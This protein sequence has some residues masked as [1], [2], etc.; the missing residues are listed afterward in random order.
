MTDMYNTKTNISLRSWLFS[1]IG[2]LFLS[3][4]AKSQVQTM[5]WIGGAGDWNDLTHWSFQSG[6]QGATQPSSVPTSETHVIF[7]SNSGLNS[8]GTTSA[9]I[10]ARTVTL[11]A[12]VVIKSLTFDASLA[13]YSPIIKNDFHIRVSENVVWQPNVTMTNSSYA[14]SM[15]PLINTTSTLTLNGGNIPYVNKSG[16][17]N[18]DII[19]EITAGRYYFTS[20]TT[21]YNAVT[22][23]FAGNNS[24]SFQV[25]NNAILNMPY[26]TKLETNVGV[27]LNGTAQFNAPLL[28]EWTGINNAFSA[29]TV[30]STVHLNLPSLQIWNLASSAAG[31]AN[32]TITIP[33]NTKITTTGG[34]LFIG[35]FNAGTSEFYIG[36]DLTTKAN[37]LLNKVH[38]TNAATPVIRGNPVINELY[39]TANGRFSSTVTI[40]KLYLSESKNYIVDNNVTI[41]ITDNIIDNTPD[42]KPFYSIVA[43]NSIS[44]GNI[45]NA[46]G[47]PINLKNA[48]ISGIK[49]TSGVINVEGIDAD[50][51]STVGTTLFFTEPAAKTIYWVGSGLDDEWN[52]QVNWSATSGGT[53]G[54]CLPTMY[55]NVIFDN[56][57]IIVGNTLKI[58]NNAANVHDL[59][60]Q[61]NFSKSTLIIGNSTININCYGS[62]YMK[63]GVSVNSP[64]LFDAKELN[65]KITSNGSTFN[66]VVTFRNIGGWVLQDDFKTGSNTNYHINFVGGTL[67]TNNKKVFIGG[68]FAGSAA[69]YPTVASGGYKNLILGSS[70]ISL[71]N[72][73]SYNLIGSNLNAGTSHII[74]R[75]GTTF[76]ALNGHTYFNVTSYPLTV[77]TSNTLTISGNNV[78]Y[79][80][81]YIYNAGVIINATN[82]NF[83]ELRIMPVQLRANV[84]ISQNITANTLELQSNAIFR[85]DNAKIITVNQDFITHTNDCMGLMEM[86]VNGKTAGQKFTLKALNN[87]F[88]PNVW[89]TGV[90][91]DTSTG[92]TYSAT[93][94]EE[95]DVLGWN[96]LVPSPKELY[97]IGT[98]DNN[99]N[100]GLNW[101][102]NSNGI[103]SAGG[104]VPTK[105]DNV[106]FNSYSTANLPIHILDQ[107]AYFNNLIAH[108]DA[109]SGIIITYPSSANMEAYAYGNLIQMGENMIFNRLYLLGGHS[110]G[111]LINKG[112]SSFGNLTVNH[113]TANW[114]FINNMKHTSTY[115]QTGATV[116]VNAQDWNGRDFAIN[117]LALNL[118]LNYLT[119]TGTF[120]L[121]KGD[122]K[123]SN[124]IM[125]VN[126]F[127]SSG[128]SPITNVRSIDIRNSKVVTKND[129]FYYNLP[130]ATLQAD[131]SHITFNRNFYGIAGHIYDVIETDAATTNVGSAYYL[132]GNI[133]ANK[134]IVNKS[135]RILDNNTF[136]TLFLKPRG[137]TLWVNNTQ[138][139]TQHLY[140]SGTP[141]FTNVLRA[142]TEIGLTQANATASINLSNSTPTIS[143][144]EN[145]FDYVRIGGINATNSKMFLQVNATSIGL[146]TNV[147]SIPGTP[148]LIGLGPDVNCQLIDPSAPST[149]LISAEKFYAGP[150]ATFTWF[151]KVNGIYQNLNLPDTTREIDVRSFGY[152]GEYKVELLYD[153]LNTDASKRCPQTDEILVSYTPPNVTFNAGENIHRFCDSINGM[154]INDF[155]VSNATN[156][157]MIDRNAT[158][159]WFSTATGGTALNATDLVVEGSYYAEL[160]SPLG[161]V[162]LQ[163]SLVTVIIDELVVANAGPD[164]VKIGNYPLTYTMAANQTTVGS[165]KWTVLSGDVSISNTLA[166]DTTVLL[167]SGDTAVLQWEI[168]NESCTTNS[169]VTLT[170][171]SVNP[172]VNPNLRVRVSN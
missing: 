118:N 126:N 39:F 128:N 144:A 73:W 149:Y 61:D 64:V 8:V 51:N 16:E 164:Q 55:D 59:T 75:N 108:N 52:N 97:W 110:D 109:P 42:C 69:V 92:A 3:L 79:N 103:P 100:N 65:E 38:L 13:Q 84:N 98:A 26:V 121:T 87:T 161:C 156:N 78:N 12:E 148:G 165:G 71:Y 155:N 5:Y 157:D 49:V 76:Q 137:L 146:N 82:S 74:F 113:P 112:T 62:W 132:G 101:T 77:T 37:T 117:G 32:A 99:W 19:G 44:I 171:S 150:E 46:S 104:C 83:Q 153:P 166:Y 35:N 106:H 70:E 43:Q 27:T 124:L 23:K 120:T 31:N 158:I 11:K 14:I 141:C 63:S 94:L 33:D 29:L 119:A 130:S 172:K 129:W 53:G 85:V 56:N 107:P 167:N 28:N 95:T 17:G 131:G 116:T 111:Q 34:W 169:S 145:T 91:A 72:S 66:Q 20:G 15:E 25:T 36:G 152:D 163:R 68:N 50:R 9:L 21:N 93:G 90:H 4:S 41:T 30:N 1:L 96:F 135:K 10:N 127:V 138:T 125:E 143:N 67:N 170:K 58:T 86:Y 139:V 160:V 18:L 40:G 24:T 45:A 48:S 60:I 142:G 105:Y 154:K 102:T 22:A 7:D 54:Y 122:L 162:S 133:V 114:T 168:T 89:M 57:S 115:T 151:K 2:F 147:E 81:F 159:R 88:V 134:Y 140:L 123:A 47:L 136:G 6:A 80:N